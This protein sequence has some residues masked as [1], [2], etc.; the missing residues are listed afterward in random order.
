[1]QAKAGQDVAN[2]LLSAIAESLP[3][4]GRALRRPE[5]L[6]STG[7]AVS[8]SWEMGAVATTIMIVLLHLEPVGDL[9]KALEHLQPAAA[10]CLR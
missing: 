1:M 10:A 5:M 3:L 2:A 4:L 9:Q 8:A 7:P 6:A